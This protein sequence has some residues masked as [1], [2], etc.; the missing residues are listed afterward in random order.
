MLWNYSA[1]GEIVAS[2]V[3]TIL[4]ITVVID[5]DFSPSVTF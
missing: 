5:F 1:A 3:F 2:G 4:T